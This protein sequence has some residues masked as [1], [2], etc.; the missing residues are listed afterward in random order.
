MSALKVRRAEPADAVAV[1]ALAKRREFTAKWS[2]AALTE[3]ASRPDAVYFV[4]VDGPIRG[5]ALAR[6][7]AKEAQLLDL[8]AAN[9]NSDDTTVFASDLAGSFVS[10]GQTTTSGCLGVSSIAAADFNS[11]GVIDVA[12]ACSGSAEV[13]ILLTKP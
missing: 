10:L 13:R 2:I 8:A 9:T 3:E 11:D 4:A 7:V 1:A 6:V 5:Y 12:L